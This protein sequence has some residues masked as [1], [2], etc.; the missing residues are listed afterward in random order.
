MCRCQKRISTTKIQLDWLLVQLNFR[1]LDDNIGQIAVNSRI[2]H[3]IVPQNRDDSSVLSSLAMKVQHFKIIPHV[4]VQTVIQPNC[5]IGKTPK[6]IQRR[7]MRYCILSG[8][9]P[10]SPNKN[11]NRI[12][13][14]TSGPAPPQ[15][16]RPVQS[17]YLDMFNKFG[18]L[19]ISQI[20]NKASKVC[21]KPR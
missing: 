10:F 6:K 3:L 21:H 7:V 15:K 1:A 19:K 5:W 16:K 17:G 18:E 13:R 4:P 12:Q 9:I 8:F 11:K 14:R 2:T 20:L